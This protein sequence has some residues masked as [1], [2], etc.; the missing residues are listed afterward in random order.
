MNRTS[1][2]DTDE[3]PRRAREFENIVVPEVPTVTGFNSWLGKL[4]H[5][6]I[7]AAA[8]KNDRPV[9]DWFGEIEAAES[10]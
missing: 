10:L 2:T 1:D 6:V 8:R 9:A 4:C 3:E 5:N 7:A